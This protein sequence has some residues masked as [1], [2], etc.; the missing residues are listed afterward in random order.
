[1]TTLRGRCLC[2]GTV[3]EEGKYLC[4][5][6]W[7]RVPAIERRKLSKRDSLAGVRLLEMNRQFSRDVP[8]EEI[9]VSA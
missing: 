6:C 3:K 5:G 8:P 4:P 9:K 2:C 7:G 1:M